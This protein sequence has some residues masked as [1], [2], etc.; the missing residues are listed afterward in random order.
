VVLKI[1]LGFKMLT[2]LSIL[3]SAF[4]IFV[5]TNGQRVPSVPY[6]GN[7]RYDP[8]LN[9]TFVLSIK[10]IANG[11]VGNVDPYVKLYSAVGEAAPEKFATSDVV[12]NSADPEFTTAFSYVWKRGTGQKWIFKL[13][14]SNTLRDTTLAEVIVDVDRYVSQREKMNVTFNP[15]TGGALY[16]QKTNPVRFRLYARNLPKLDPPFN[17]GKSDPF[18]NIYWSRGS[19]GEQYK[20]ARSSTIDNVENADWNET[21][22]FPQYIRGTDLWLHYQVKDEDGIGKDE[23]LGDAL[24]EVDPFVEKR[25]TK[26]LNLGK[27]GA[28]KA[29]LGVTPA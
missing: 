21:F 26:I 11:G 16:I 15:P 19:K 22:E 14:D 8:D 28:G 10:G 18:V 7:I 25:Q 29:T 1:K 12:K 23:D 5:V 13:K 6:N 27:A 24:L 3:F 9:L 17:K 4:A 20:L 2:P